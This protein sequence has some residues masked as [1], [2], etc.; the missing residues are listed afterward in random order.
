MPRNVLFSSHLA[1]AAVRPILLAILTFKS[2]TVYVWSGVGSLTYGGHTYLG[3]GS[4]GRISRVQEGTDVHAYGMSVELSG[5]DSTL[6]AESMADIQLGALAQ[7]Y[8]GLL[9]AS[10]NIYGSPYCF[11]S[12]AIDKPTITPGLKT[13]TISLALETKMSN[14]ARPTRRR[15][16]AA[17]QQLYYPG[18]TAFNWVEILNDQALKWA[19]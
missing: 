10:G 4:L 9:D 12:G 14:L 5:I 13:I 2:A 6:L 3:V 16:T 11:F 19:L 1:D 15:Y 8:F 7:L 18:D 17:D